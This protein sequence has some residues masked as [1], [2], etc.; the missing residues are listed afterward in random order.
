MQGKHDFDA[1]EEMRK[2]L[3]GRKIVCNGCGHTTVKGAAR[4]MRKLLFFFCP[5][6]WEDRRACEQQ[7]DRVSA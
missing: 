4:V 6:C 7:M 2:N 3:V 5:S 1:E